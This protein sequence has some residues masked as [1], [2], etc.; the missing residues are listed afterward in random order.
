M[1]LLTMAQASERLG[2]SIIHIRR[3]CKSGSIPMV[4][5]PGGKGNRAI[6][7]F[8]DERVV[9]ELVP[10]EN[11]LTEEKLIQEEVKTQAIIT[12]L[13]TAVVSMK[14]SNMEFKTEYYKKTNDIKKEKSQILD[15]NNTIMLKY[16]N[17]IYERFSII[18]N[19]ISALNQT[20]N[21]ILDILQPQTNGLN[22][23]TLTPS[24]IPKTKIK[25]K[26]TNPL[27]K[28]GGD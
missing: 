17:K 21:K 25:Q 26:T 9:N 14:R 2:L 7:Y 15:I 8:I 3:M 27:E 28:F 16:Q 23:D 4:T 18:D 1:V 13:K 19:D 12:E 24:P 5:L 10:K 6:K 11:S 22:P 20:M